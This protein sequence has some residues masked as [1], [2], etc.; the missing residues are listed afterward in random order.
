MLKQL[1]GRRKAGQ[2]FVRFLAENLEKI[3]FERS[4]S[5]PQFF[6]N[7]AR[8]VFIELHFDAP[9]ELRRAPSVLRTSF[10]GASSRALSRSAG[11]F[12]VYDSRV[13]RRC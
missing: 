4:E 6:V 8:Q 9:A 1:Q 13:T 7:R 12:K 11:A 10:V 2:M 3:G 5:A